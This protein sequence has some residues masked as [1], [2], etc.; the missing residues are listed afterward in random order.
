ME[1][2]E[3][4]DSSYPQKAVLITLEIIILG[5]SYWI[6]FL[7]GYNRVFPSST[8]VTG[9]N[10]RH[11]FIFIFNIVV[12]LRILFTIFFLLKRRIPW[13]ETFS[14]PLAFA[15]YYIGFALFGFKSLSPIGATG[16]IAI[17]LFIIGSFL[18]TGSEITREKWKKRP[19]NKGHL[20]TTG[21]F[22]YSMHINYFGDLVWVSA[23]AMITANWY[24]VSIPVFLFCFFA[25]YNIPKLDAYLTSKYG[26]EFDQYRAKT[27]K[28]IPFL[29]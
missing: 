25:F 21:L 2:Y 22:R 15:L 8:Q 7:N 13:E 10:L 1:L 18:N 14:I 17:G 16:Y 29:Y 3:R 11:I 24:A 26:K 6:L 23:Y 4:K 20:Y 28:F 27:K 9:N 19:E 12:F 5:I